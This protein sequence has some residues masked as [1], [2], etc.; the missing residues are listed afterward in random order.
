[1]AS[2]RAAQRKDRGRPAGRL[3]RSAPRVW[4]GVCVCACVAALVLM[5]GGAGAMLVRGQAES[6]QAKPAK[7]D[8][9]KQSPANQA[10]GNQ[11]NPASQ[12]SDQNSQP[13]QGSQVVPGDPD[14][15]MAPDPDAPVVVAP[16]VDAPAVVNGEPGARPGS[17]SLTGDAAKS[18]AGAPGDVNPAVAGPPAVPAGPLTPEE[19]RKQDVAI[20]CAD[21]LKMATDLK[22]EVDKSSKDE[23]SIGVIR[24]AGQI[25]QYAHKVRTAP[26]LT[27]TTNGQESAREVAKH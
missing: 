3:W 25:E 11:A 23:L 17:N 8:P 15:T 24:K 9:A 19:K 22:A 12:N 5:L 10:P 16:V 27:V 2:K 4:L 20:A 13:A 7:Q 26:Q 18:D 1:M 6:P 14:A 21:L